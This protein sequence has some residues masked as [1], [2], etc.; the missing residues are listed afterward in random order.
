MGARFDRISIVD[1]EGVGRTRVDLWG[2][3]LSPD[4][5]RPYWLPGARQRPPGSRSIAN[6]TAARTVARRL[7]RAR[8]RVG[9]GESPRRTPWCVISSDS[10]GDRQVGPCLVALSIRRCP[11]FDPLRCPPLHRRAPSSATVL[12][13]DLG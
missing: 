7:W 10:G 11:V 1:L 4:I 6:F 13:A 2:C 12:V 8:T 5:R 9:L 3:R